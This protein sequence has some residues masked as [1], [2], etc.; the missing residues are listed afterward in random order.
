MGLSVEDES[1]ILTF[2]LTYYCGINTGSKK[3]C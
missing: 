1:I 3:S 2:I